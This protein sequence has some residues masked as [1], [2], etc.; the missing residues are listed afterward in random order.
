MTET[1][2]QALINKFRQILTARMRG[3]KAEARAL[4]DDITVNDFPIMPTFVMSHGVSGDAEGALFY[5]DHDWDDHGG[6]DPNWCNLFIVDVIEV[7]EDVVAS[8]AELDDD[9][10]RV[11]N[12]ESV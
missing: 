9:A 10:Q 5:I 6:T 11:R 7:L 4:F 1:D 12:N 3:H 2:T 8:H